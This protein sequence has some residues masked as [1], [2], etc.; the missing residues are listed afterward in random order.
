MAS[1]RVFK[2]FLD[3]LAIEAKRKQPVNK[4]TI[5]FN[6]QDSS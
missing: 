6:T 2:R 4:K 1:E 3:V 5:V